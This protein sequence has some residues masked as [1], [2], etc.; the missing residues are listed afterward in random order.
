M[1][2]KPKMLRKI[3]VQTY[4]WSIYWSNHKT[5]PTCFEFKL[6]FQEKKIMMIAYERDL[7]SKDANTC[8]GDLYN[9]HVFISLHVNPYDM[10]WLWCDLT[11]FCLSANIFITK[12]A[13]NWNPT[14]LVDAILILLY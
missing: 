10:L 4:A 14:R 7:M 9:H 8:S 13:Q 5:Y 2:A 3:S 6:S 1:Q 11:I 12:F